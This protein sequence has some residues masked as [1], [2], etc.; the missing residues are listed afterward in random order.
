MTGDEDAASDARG[1]AGQHLDDTVRLGTR[2]V[3]GPEGGR[4]LVMEFEA[5]VATGKDGEMLALERAAAI[6]EVLARIARNRGRNDGGHDHTG[7]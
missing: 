7:S 2:T 5:K 3:S 4:P 6:R 1:G